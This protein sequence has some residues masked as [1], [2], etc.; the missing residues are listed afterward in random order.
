MIKKFEQFINEGVKNKVTLQY[1]VNKNDLSW[2]IHFPDEEGITVNLQE[3]QPEGDRIKLN[4][5]ISFNN[6]LSDGL[7]NPN[8]AK[9]I[10]LKF[11][12]DIGTSDDSIPQ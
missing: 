1:E 3:S 9:K 5:Y 7:G 6:V 4:G 12:S 8:D 11:L 10:I 2:H